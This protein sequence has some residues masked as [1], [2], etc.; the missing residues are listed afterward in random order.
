MVLTHESPPSTFDVPLVRRASAG[1]A[2]AFATL[3]ERYADPVRRLVR[4]FVR[5]GDDARDVEQDTWI[6]A[7]NNMGSL[8]DAERF[9]PWVKAIAR[10]ASLDYLSS[11][12]RRGAH[13]TTFEVLGKDDFEDEVSPTPEASVLSRDSQRKV[14][15]ALGTLSDR[16]RSA[17][18][19]REY[20]GLPYSEVAKELGVSRNAAEVCA[21]R[22]RERFRSAFT[23]VDADI[24]E[25]GVDGLRLSTLLQPAQGTPRAERLELESH[26]DSCE[27]CQ[28]RLAAMDEG[29]TLYRNLG[30]FGFPIPGAGIFGWAADLLAKLGHLLGLTAGGGAPTVGAGVSMTA[31]AAVTTGASATAAGIGGAVSAAAIATTAA[32]VLIVSVVMPVASAP[33]T[34]VAA[35]A[36]VAAPGGTSGAVQGMPAADSTPS[37]PVVPQVVR[38]PHADGRAAGHP[39][40]APTA[41][42]PVVSPAH[43]ITS[44]LPPTS[45]ASVAPA[46]VATVVAS[47]LPSG[48]PQTTA[49]ASVDAVPPPPTEGPA[50]SP[51]SDTGDV[52]PGIQATTART[53][54]PPSHSS[55]AAR[56]AASAQSIELVAVTAG[57]SGN[58]SGG[59]PPGRAIVGG[60]GGGS[61]PGQ[62]AGNVPGGSSPGHAAQANGPGGGS[63]PGQAAQAN[64]HGGGSPPGQ[65]A[66]ANDSG[67]GSPPGHA[68]QANG[69][70][71]GN[72]PGH[73]AQGND[74]GGGSPPGHAVAGKA[75]K[76]QGSAG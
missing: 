50:P 72:P 31:G 59:T 20:K 24:P 9:Q 53:T 8:L 1:D 25:C 43:G 70:G 52:A 30:A 33:P 4:R 61:P 23:A 17:L 45:P 40:V 29:R 47:A 42:P 39:L 73:A 26:R 76:G 54:G 16:D 37:T 69:S 12:K 14:W 35:V 75:P 21:H 57:G 32:A 3:M 38:L 28:R 46:P 6:R 10:N 49:T 56:R 71:G 55:A 60:P 36:P 22:A 44:A 34:P 66:Q 67:G 13:V 18:F 11:R 64:G 68:A 15:Q 27:G 51:S 5:D 58:G 62:A 63:P 41:S 48:A 74:P 65:A 2:E 7:A 19:L